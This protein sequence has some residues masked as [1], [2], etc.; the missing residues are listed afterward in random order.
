MVTATP[1]THEAPSVG[2]TGLEG[3]YRLQCKAQT[4]AWGLPAHSSEVRGAKAG[5]PRTGGWGS[6]LGGPQGAWD[7]SPSLL[8]YVF[9]C[10]PGGQPVQGWRTDH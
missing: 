2:A 9:L 5:T 7:L 4:Y 10:A 1:A 8:L 3:L 6:A